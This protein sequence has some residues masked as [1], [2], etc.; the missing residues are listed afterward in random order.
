MGF[1]RK[2]LNLEF[3]DPE[4]EG[5]KVSARR[6]NVDQLLGIGNLRH[7]AKLKDDSPEVREGLKQVFA[8]LA[9]DDETQGI[10]LRW[11]LEEP[12]DPSDPDGPKVP[13]PLTAA[14]LRQQDLPLIMSIVDAITDATTAVP[15]DLK[16]ESSAGVPSEE[17]QMPMEPLSPSPTS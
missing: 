15:A 2:T 1:V 5:F 4:L 6:L 7:L 12:A 11:N 17:L 13:V 9:G 10:L 3:D 16:A 8:T 14:T